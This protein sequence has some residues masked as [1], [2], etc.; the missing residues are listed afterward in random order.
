MAGSISTTAAASRRSGKK[1]SR[2]TSPKATPT[3]RPSAA[4]DDCSRHVDDELAAADRGRHAGVGGPHDRGRGARR[5]RWR[6]GAGPVDSS[7]ASPA[8]ISATSDS[9]RSDAM[10][11]DACW[12]GAWPRGCRSPRWSGLGRGS[13][14]IPARRSSAAASFRGRGCR[15]T[16]PPGSG[17]AGRR[18]FSR[19]CCWRSPSGRRVLVLTTLA[20]GPM[21][22]RPLE[23]W[24]G[25]P[26][27]ARL[28][29]A[30]LTVLVLR[31]RTVTRRCRDARAAGGA[32]GAMAPL[33]VLAVVGAERA[34]C[35][36]GR[37]AGRSP[38]RSPRLHRR[39]SRH[40]RRRRRR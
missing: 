28:V 33:G 11:D 40:R 38:P 39:Q 36:V 32:R 3:G 21:M 1:T 26:W 2:A 34:D 10:A 17:D 5:A 15:C 24:F 35:R 14:A 12:D 23:G 25:A 6:R 13:I 20:F 4:A 30:C 7:R 8:S 27:V 16:S 31:R 29:V 22:A 37:D 18:R 9:G 19:G